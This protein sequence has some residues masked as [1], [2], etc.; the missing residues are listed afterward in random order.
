VSPRSRRGFCWPGPQGPPPDIG[1]Q[2]TPDVGP[3]R[4]HKRIPFRGNRCPIA[5]DPGAARGEKQG[6]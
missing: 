5:R 3:C 2:K 1:R 6:E 4:N